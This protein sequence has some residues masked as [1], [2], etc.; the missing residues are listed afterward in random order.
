MGERLRMFIVALRADVLFFVFV[1]FL[2]VLVGGFFLS[3]FR[4]DNQVWEVSGYTY[5]VPVLV[6][7]FLVPS[8]M[9]LPTSILPVRVLIH[10][11]YIADRAILTRVV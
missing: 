11:Y 1:L 2:F 5:T 3:F 10:A 4:V 6:L 7:Y 8:H 9:D